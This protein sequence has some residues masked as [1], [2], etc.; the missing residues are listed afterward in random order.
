MAEEK[1]VIFDGTNYVSIDIG[2][3]VCTEVEGRKRSY[4]GLSADVGKLPT[5][6]GLGTGSIALCLDTGDFY[7]YHGPTK[8]WYKL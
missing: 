3:F 2:S 5:Y 4:E 6:D 1:E 7:K 8:T